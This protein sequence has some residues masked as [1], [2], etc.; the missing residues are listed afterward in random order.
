MDILQ[1]AF[2]IKDEIIRNRRHLHSNPEIGLDL[3]KTAE[4]VKARLVEMGY[5]PKDCGKNG[6]V[7]TVGKGDKTFLIRG[8]MDALLMREESGLEF[9]SKCDMAHTC[10]HDMHTSMLLGAAKLLKEMEDDLP[11][12]VKLMF[13][14]GEEHIIG[15]K[16]MIE[17]G[18]LE[19]PKVDAG[20]AI[21]VMALEPSGVM[22]YNI[23]PAA[24]SSDMF[25]I[26]ITGIGGHGA[27]PHL[28]VDPINVGSHMVIALQELIA[29]EVAPMDTAV[30]TVGSFK[31][32][33][34]CNIIPETAVLKGTIRTYDNDVRA[35][36]VKRLSEV[37]H[38][39]CETFRAEVKVEFQGCTPPMINNAEISETIGKAMVELLGEENVISNATPMSGS[40]DFAYVA[41]K[42]PTVFFTLGANPGNREPVYGQHHPKVYFDESVLHIGSAAYVKGALSWFESQK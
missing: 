12:T 22:S 9:A 10:G 17:H 30:L 18:L 19:N 33:D 21:H 38:G 8:D 29:R 20:M 42:V 11:G 37:A 25:E 3:P 31:S 35:F 15:A 1:R 32:G 14:P 6:I 34:A 40:E 26:T 39:V 36:L 27:N 2:E 4:F 41:E 24:A 5:T 16:E 7:V 28:S 23:G 13:Q